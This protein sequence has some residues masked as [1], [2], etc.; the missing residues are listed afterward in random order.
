MSGAW[1][2]PSDIS[3]PIITEVAL[4]VSFSPSDSP[5]SQVKRT[6]SL[7]YMW[8]TGVANACAISIPSLGF[9][10]QHFA[11][12]AAA[13]AASRGL[14]QKKIE[15]GI[16]L[17]SKGD[18]KHLGEF[19]KGPAPFSIVQLKEIGVSLAKNC[20]RWGCSDDVMTCDV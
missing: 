15:K 19:A 2:Q 1:L 13:A 3:F 18:K 14:S 17:M 4:S 10:E 16:G 11:V 5:P 12:A 20:G 6:T 7:H 9:D 8:S